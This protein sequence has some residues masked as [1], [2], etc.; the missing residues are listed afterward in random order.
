MADAQVGD[1]PAKEPRALRSA[2]ADG[3]NAA[4]RAHEPWRAR[5]P[6][7]PTVEPA[8]TSACGVTSGG[9]TVVLLSNIR[10]GSGSTSSAGRGGTSTLG[11]ST[12]AH[13]ESSR[14]FAATPKHDAAT[15]MR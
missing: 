13:F 3:H 10:R 9:C 12:T 6:G 11:F 7:A 8:S 1:G 4:R 15:V 5:A 2:A 14:D